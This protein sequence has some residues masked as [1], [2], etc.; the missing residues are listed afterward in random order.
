MLK[1]YLELGQIVSTHGIK[2][3]MRV[4]P[5]CDSPEFA[6]VFKTVYLDD[7]GE[8]PFEENE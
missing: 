3:E 2:G 5:W 4:N 7:K 6:C 1:P 8:T